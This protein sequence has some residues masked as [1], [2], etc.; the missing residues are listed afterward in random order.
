MSELRRYR[1]QVGYTWS[2]ADHLNIRNG[3]M[4]GIR[5]KAKVSKLQLPKRLSMLEWIIM[6]D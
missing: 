5:Q 3:W 2:T 1:R 4:L 6:P